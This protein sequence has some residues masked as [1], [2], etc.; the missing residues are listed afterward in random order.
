MKSRAIIELALCAASGRGTLRARFG[1]GD[2][3]CVFDTWQSFAFF[4]FLEQRLALDSL[5][6]SIWIALCSE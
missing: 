4:Y 1:Q 3:R 6:L 2:S 5:H